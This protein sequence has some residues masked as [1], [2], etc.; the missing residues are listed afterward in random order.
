MNKTVCG[1]LMCFVLISPALAEAKDAFKK[2]ATAKSL[3][4]TFGPGA[5]SNWKAGYPK[6]EKD[7]FDVALHFDSINL[8]TKTARLIGSQGAADVTLYLLP[9][10]LTFAEETGSGNMV[11]TTIFASQKEGTDEFIAVTSRHMDLMGSPLPSQYHGTC[12]I[13]E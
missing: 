4:C 6:I 2:L 10:G 11:F 3:K 13:L 12:K 5:F 1:I 9:S 8:K 7:R